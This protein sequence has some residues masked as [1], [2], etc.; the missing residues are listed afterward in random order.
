MQKNIPMENMLDLA[1][2]GLSHSQIAK[3]LGCSRSN[4]T[5]RLRKYRSHLQGLKY[6]RQNRGDV[7]AIM[8][9]R[10]LGSITDQDIKEMPT[11]QRVTVAEKLYN[12][13][14]LETGKSTTNL[15][16]AQVDPNDTLIS[17]FEKQGLNFFGS[18]RYPV[19][20]AR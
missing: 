15:L 19:G 6:Y 9:K 5:A 18:C 12:M 3:I 4:V 8:E 7:F 10:F 2:K 16:Y 13:G 11:H 17:L 14:R 1:G 20:I